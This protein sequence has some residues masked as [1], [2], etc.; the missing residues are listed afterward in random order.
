[1]LA[2]MAVALQACIGFTL[3]GSVCD[4]IDHGGH[5][6]TRPKT[7]MMAM[8]RV[9]RVLVKGADELLA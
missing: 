5:D 9:S 7:Y 6:N 3:V 2:A 8:Q 1:M 4:D